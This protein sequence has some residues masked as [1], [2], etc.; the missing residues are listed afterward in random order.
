MAGGCQPA[1]GHFQSHTVMGFDAEPCSTDS[2]DPRQ[3]AFVR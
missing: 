1:P 2:V 3:A